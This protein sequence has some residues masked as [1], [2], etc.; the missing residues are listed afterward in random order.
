MELEPELDQETEPD[1]SQR[2]RLSLKDFFKNLSTQSKVK[3]CENSVQNS[4]MGKLVGET[5]LSPS[6]KRRIAVV[7]KLLK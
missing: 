5:L 7:K 6:K 3:N 1:R 2:G 4:P